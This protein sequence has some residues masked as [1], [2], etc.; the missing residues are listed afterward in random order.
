MPRTER[1]LEHLLRPSS[2]GVGLEVAG[3]EPGAAQLV[4]ARL[5]PGAYEVQVGDR[6]VRCEHD[7]GPVGIEVR[8]LTPDQAHEVVLRDGDDVLARSRLHTPRAPAGAELCRIATISDLHLGR[9]THRASMVS[10]RHANSADRT[11]A[12]DTDAS[13]GRGDERSEGSTRLSVHQDRASQCARAAMREAAAWGAELIVVKGDICEETFD[14]T[15]DLAAEVLGEV[16][17]PVLLLPGN[18]DTGTLRRFEPEDGA[19]ARGL[20][21]VRGVGHVD[22]PGLRVIAVDSTV[23]GRSPGAIA[24]HAPE[25]ADLV[26]DVRGDGGA[27]VATH[28]QPQRWSVPLYWPPGIPGPDARRFART[29]RA[30]NPAVLASSGHTHRNR[31]RRVDGMDWSEVAATSHF[32]AVWAGYTVHEGGLH[33]TVRR[34]VDPEV[35]TWS[36]HSRRMLAG[37]WAL[38]SAGSVADRS[39][40]L[41]W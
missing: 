37:V 13:D 11:T 35:L 12:R 32:P 23:P 16:D 7:G 30:A 27:F 17:V 39:F 25:V 22:L 14:E 6:R 28:H 5:G 34:I 3:V 20:E 1:D 38:W 31:H 40:T 26:R 9:D 41:D 15:W 21:L 36:E 4:V 8:G 2:A 10:G 29:V 19:A 24:R 18:H 33:Q